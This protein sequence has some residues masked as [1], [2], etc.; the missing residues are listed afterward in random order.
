MIRFEILSKE[1]VAR[2]D[3]LWA[4]ELAEEAERQQLCGA[5]RAEHGEHDWMLELEDPEDDDQ[6]GVNL[7]CTR[8]PAGID[9]VYPD[10]HDLIWLEDHNGE[11]L[12][13]GGRHFSSVSL[14][15]PVDVKVWSSTSWTGEYDV[16]LQIS[17]RDLGA[18][19]AT[20]PPVDD[21]KRDEGNSESNYEGK[22][23]DQQ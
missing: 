7:Y 16:E 15:I 14:T 4:Q 19:S 21:G 20:L 17:R 1:E 6:P 8:C 10:G 23:E 18:A 12:V 11:W 13:K 9:D 5:C 3:V 22:R 2:L